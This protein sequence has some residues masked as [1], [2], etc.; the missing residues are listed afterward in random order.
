MTPDEMHLMQRTFKNRL[1]WGF[2]TCLYKFVNDGMPMALT[3]GMFILFVAFVCEG[4]RTFQRFESGTA[5]ASYVQARYGVEM[6]WREAANM[7]IVFEPPTTA[8]NRQGDVKA[9]P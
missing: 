3:V 7:T 2:Q 1:R 4:L 5:K 9:N 8:T 6:S